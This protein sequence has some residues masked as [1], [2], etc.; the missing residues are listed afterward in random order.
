MH[1]FLW[2]TVTTTN[3]SALRR[4]YIVRN[5]VYIFKSFFLSQPV[6]LTAKICNLIK[7]FIF[8]NEQKVKFKVTFIGFVD[9]L[10]SQTGKCKRDF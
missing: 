5:T 2:M 6:L 9:G 8:E 1:E 4:Y 7:I 3:H 10:F